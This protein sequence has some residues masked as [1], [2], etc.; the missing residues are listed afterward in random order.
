[1]AC[2]AGEGLAAE[3]AGPLTLVTVE[4]PI[5]A[6]AQDEEALAWVGKL[7]E[8]GCS[9]T[10]FPSSAVYIRTGA[11][12]PVMRLSEPFCSQR[13][14]D[15]AL[16]GR[17]VLWTEWWH[18]NNTYTEVVTAEIGKSSIGLERP[19][20]D[21]PGLFGDA[22]GTGEYFG[23]LAGDKN[24]LAYSVIVNYYDDCD[25]VEEGICTLYSTQVAKRVEGRR[26]RRVPNAEGG[27][28][29]VSA[30]NVAT[31][32]ANKT[33]TVRNAWTG[34]VVSSF[35]TT[36]VPRSIALTQTLV[37]ILVDRGRVRRVEL[38]NIQTG[39]LS[40]SVVVPRK[41]E[42]ISAAGHTVA[43]SVGRYVFALDARTFRIRRLARAA[44]APIG[45]SIE[46]KRIAWAENVRGHGAIR[47]VYTP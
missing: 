33:I 27:A 14:S 20:S 21:S 35:P 43:Y 4:H 22:D 12:R 9:E 45:L 3:K 5:E 28:L 31:V 34:R 6:F 19:E 26:A 10:S 30:P 36:G 16:A 32:A 44:H 46:G 24:L 11:S 39:A 23:S 42:K 25:P 8:P 37:A 13:P 29:A 18:G 41:T 7:E 17:R 1:M 38:R 40:R 47:A 15:L 2:A